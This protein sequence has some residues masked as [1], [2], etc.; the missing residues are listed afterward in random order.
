MT[1]DQRALLLAQRVKA[2]PEVAMRARWT[3]EA[4]ER[5][6]VDE[7]LEVLRS[8]RDCA[9]GRC[10]AFSEA[11]LAIS[12]A[13]SEPAGEA[14]R[15]RLLAHA[16]CSGA[17][18]LEA[19]LDQGPAV[20]DPRASK[21]P[22]FGRGRPPTL[23]ERKSLARTRDRELLSRVLRDPHPDVMRIL[24]DNPR[25]TE[26]DV[27]RAA[28]AR[29]VA[30]QVLR[31]IFLSTRWIIRPSVQTTLVLNPHC[32]RELALFLVPQL[33]RT[34]ARRALDVAG[35]DAMVLSACRGVVHGGT[36]H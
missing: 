34:D 2:L 16:R 36:R 19:L 7:S 33:S 30:G 24:L 1:P 12:L 11:W 17:L 4:L 28:S 10:P 22:E 23:G 13:L 32:P 15:R 18:E 31:E 14:L 21:L 27:L 29:P 25:L 9:V 8:A 5:L 20:D 35:L 26:I 6:P 3:R